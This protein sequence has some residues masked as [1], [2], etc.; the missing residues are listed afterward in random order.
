MAI[1]HKNENKLDDRLENLELVSKREHLA[2]HLPAFQGKTIAALV[3]ARRAKR[4]STKSATKRTG[5]HPA[6]CTCEVH[7]RST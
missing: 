5:R 1:H 7:R 4:W 3:S 2:G 6:G